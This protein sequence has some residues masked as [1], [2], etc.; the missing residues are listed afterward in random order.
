MVPDLLFVAAVMFGVLL[1]AV[2]SIM[3][4]TRHDRRAKKTE[5]PPS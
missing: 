1:I 5:L 3:W 2:G 4:T